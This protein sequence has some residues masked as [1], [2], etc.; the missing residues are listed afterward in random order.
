[1][2]P[3]FDNLLG[4]STINTY[5][6]YSEATEENDGQTPWRPPQWADESQLTYLV[7]D[8]GEGNSIYH[9]FDAVFKMDHTSA[10][11]I[12]EHPIQTGA[13]ISDHAYVLPSSVVL[14][15]GISDAMDSVKPDQYGGAESKSVSAY[16][17]LKNIQTN[18]IPVGVATRL[19]QYEVMLLERLSSEDEAKT[20]YAGRFIAEF[21][22]IILSSV[23]TDK[24][25]TKPHATDLT[26]PSSEQS[27]EPPPE[28]KANHKKPEP[29]PE[30]PSPLIP[31]HRPGSGASG[32]WSSGRGGASGSW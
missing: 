17:I 32:D 31:S 16:Q 29:V 3:A 7:A 1:M 20:L 11:R 28:L 15:I 19:F 25:S 10:L 9:F 18:R 13:N 22:Q 21:K 12:T 6:T 14:S 23:A 4:R 24:V 26:P 5:Q 2:S 30:A 27:I 8:D